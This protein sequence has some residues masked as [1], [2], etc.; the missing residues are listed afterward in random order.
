MLQKY[1][2]YKNK[3]E[4]DDDEEEPEGSGLEVDKTFKKF[5][6]RIQREPGQVLR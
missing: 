4:K 2:D 3:G 1:E 5:S 6:K